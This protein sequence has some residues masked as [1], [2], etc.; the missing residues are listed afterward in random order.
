[1]IIYG[2]RGISSEVEPVNFFCPQCGC[3]QDGRIMQVRNYFTLY[4]IPLIPLNVHGRYIEC[5]ACRGTYNE[6]VLAFS[7]EQDQF[8]QNERL[9]RVMVMAA[10]ADGV[11]DEGERSAINRQYSEISGVPLL[12]T[13]LETEIQMAQQSGA[14][15][16][17]YVGSFA[18][19]LSDQEKG[20]LVKV[21]YHTMV[22]S[23]GLQAGHKQQLSQLAA[24]LEIPKPMYM[25]LLK[26]LSGQA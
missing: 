14:D 10:L 4:F 9:L 18:N 20:I 19:E 17:Q 26:Q 7:E 16:N 5:P 25:D 1:M 3:K 13:D 12:A 24:T 11:A 6:E 23:G 22:G 2:S 8:T 21:A 15:L